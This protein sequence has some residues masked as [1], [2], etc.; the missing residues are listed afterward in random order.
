MGFGKILE[1]GADAF[2]S[3]ELLLHPGQ[4]HLFADPSPVGYDRESA[5]LLTRRTLDS[6]GRAD[7]CTG[8]R[9]QALTGSNICS[10]VSE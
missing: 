3:I 7:P 10:I 1:R 5:A 8:R 4:Q 6:P 9:A 2:E